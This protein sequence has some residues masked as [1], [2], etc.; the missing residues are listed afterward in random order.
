MRLGV[1]SP[2]CSDYLHRLKMMFSSISELKKRIWKATQKDND[3]AV[4][5][6]DTQHVWQV[7]L[8]SV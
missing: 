4:L 1:C 2:V 3:G 8:S 7:R 6:I 5:H